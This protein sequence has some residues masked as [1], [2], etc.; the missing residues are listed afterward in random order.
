MVDADTLA[1]FAAIAAPS[2]DEEARLRW[3]ERRLRDAPG[4]RASDRSSKPSSGASAMLVTRN[5]P[6]VRW[7]LNCARPAGRLW[8]ACD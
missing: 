2:G 1:E 7:P 3:L 6:P 8:S 4:D 5:W